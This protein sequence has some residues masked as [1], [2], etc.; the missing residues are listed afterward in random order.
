VSDSLC[1]QTGTKTLIDSNLVNLNCL[2]IGRLVVQLQGGK[3]KGVDAALLPD[4]LHEAVH[5][6]CFNTPVGIALG[7]LQEQLM[8]AMQSGAA[9]GELGALYIRYNTA[10]KTLGPLIEGM[11]LFAE[12]DLV[13][14]DGNLRVTPLNWLAILAYPDLIHSNEENR[15]TEEAIRSAIS[16]LRCVEATAARKDNLLCQPLDPRPLGGYLTGYMLVKGLW[17]QAVT[18]SSLARDTELW[19]AFLRAWIFHDTELA[20]ELQQPAEPDLRVID[21]A[22]PAE[23]FMD[24]LH[25]LFDLDA[26]TSALAAFNAAYSPGAAPGDDI[27]ALGMTESSRE[28]F[29]GA[30]REHIDRLELPAESES[31]D[32]ARSLTRLALHTRSWICVASKPGQLRCSKSGGLD[33]QAASGPLRIMY[34][35][36]PSGSPPRGVPVETSSSRAAT[37]EFWVGPGGCDALFVLASMSGAHAHQ[38][39]WESDSAERAAFLSGAISNRDAF[40]VNQWLSENM[41]KMI[42]S[43]EF[44]ATLSAAV[45]E[46]LDGAWE[47][48]ADLAIALYG[49]GAAARQAMWDSGLF[50]V[51]RNGDV[52]RAAN[53]LTLVDTLGEDESRNVDPEVRITI[54]TMMAVDGARHGL[55]LTHLLTGRILL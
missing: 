3:P 47:K 53:A 44:A 26:T 43:P 19:L 39:V 30:F 11:A 42:K 12:Y 5:H 14:G 38:A 1:S 31:V 55:Q 54:E 28:R 18:R 36:L 20:W 7:I 6:W 29:E 8:E 37:Y 49:G 17:L 48:Q 23:H 21:A 2:D 4:V 15:T 25:E 40:T 32:I 45:D 51:V 33:F 41:D 27:R 13:P 9:P 16:R 34:P 50:S 24:R 22:D 46:Y 35:P 10:S 52:L